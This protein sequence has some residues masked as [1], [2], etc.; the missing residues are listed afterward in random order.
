MVRKNVLFL[1]FSHFFL[2]FFSL[3]P[4]QIT[5]LFVAS[6]PLQFCSEH[7]TND[8]DSLLYAI[9]NAN[10]FIHVEVMDYAASTLYLQNN[11]YWPLIRFNYIFII[12]L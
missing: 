8:I 12:F 6:S 9:N 1:L 7:R 10:D 11:I 4:D 3:F 2:T 5:K